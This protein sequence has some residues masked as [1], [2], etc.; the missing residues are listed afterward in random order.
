MPENFAG[1]LAELREAQSRRVGKRGVADHSTRISHRSANKKSPAARPGFVDV[2]EDGRSEAESGADQRRYLDLII[3]AD[4]G[5]VRI[6]V[7]AGAARCL[8]KAEVRA[9]APSCG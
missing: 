4:A 5:D 2:R 3:H 7:V 6:Q 1:A 9:E 8:I